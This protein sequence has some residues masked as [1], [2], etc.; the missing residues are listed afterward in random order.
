MSFGFALGFLWM[1]GCC[2]LRGTADTL[3]VRNLLRYYRIPWGRVVAVE[4]GNGLRLLLAGQR[5]LT[6]VVLQPSPIE[7]LRGNP[8]QGRRC[9]VS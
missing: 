3:R 1:A 4:K 8:D 7:S 6:V 9:A 5:R 2:S